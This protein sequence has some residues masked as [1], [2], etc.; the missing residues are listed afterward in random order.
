MLSWEEMLSKA[1]TYGKFSSSLWDYAWEITY[2][3]LSANQD[4]N[5]KK[6]C[7]LSLREEND[8]FDFIRFPYLKDFSWGETL[9]N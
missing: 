5:S 7:V 8:D 1:F 6:P 2:F 4:S 9:L 3:G